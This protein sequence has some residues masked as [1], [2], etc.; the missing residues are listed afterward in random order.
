MQYYRVDAN[1]QL[2]LV[3]TDLD[4]FDPRKSRNIF[5]FHVPVTENAIEINGPWSWFTAKLYVISD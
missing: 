4:L 5:L 1:R 3:M 2:A